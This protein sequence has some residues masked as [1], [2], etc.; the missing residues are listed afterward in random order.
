MKKKSNAPKYPYVVKAQRWFAFVTPTG[1]AFRFEA[2]N[3]GD[4]DTKVKRWI[5]I[6]GI[7][8]PGYSYREL[9]DKTPDAE[10]LPIRTL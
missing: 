8:A 5:R 3:S 4:A 7:P 6:K 1:P 2:L 10:N 9:T